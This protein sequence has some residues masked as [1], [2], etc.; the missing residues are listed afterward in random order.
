MNVCR[1]SFLLRAHLRSY[2]HL[3]NRHVINIV[4][5]GERSIHKLQT[6]PVQ[7][8]K[9]LDFKPTTS[10]TAK[11]GSFYFT[12]LVTFIELSMKILVFFYDIE[13]K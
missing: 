13:F 4:A 11:V 5:I 6:K 12:A 10:N 9:H 2:E 1:R 3:Y 8:S 7:E